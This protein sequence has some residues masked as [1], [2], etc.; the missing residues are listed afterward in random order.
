M[1]NQVPEK[2]KR[3]TK[4]TRGSVYERRGIWYIRFW[5]RGQEY[6]E[7]SKSTRK[8]DAEKLLDRR[9]KEVLGGRLSGPDAQRVTFE[10]LVALIEQDYAANS[11]KSTKDM[12]GRVARLREKLGKLI[13]VDV[14]HAKL[15]EYVAARQAEGARN[16]TIRY[17]LSIL[18]RMY[19]LAIQAGLLSNKPSCPQ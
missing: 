9:R 5:F 4:S 7:S 8:R 13:P 2:P 17:E 18:G 16:A 6:R 11:R 10:H 12:L 15:K 14:T 1:E 19:V 3:R